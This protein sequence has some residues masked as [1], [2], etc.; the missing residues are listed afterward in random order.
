MKTETEIELE[1]ILTFNESEQEIGRLSL[2]TFFPT[3]QA[4]VW[5]FKGMIFSSGDELI[6]VSMCVFHNSATPEWYR[7]ANGKLYA[8]DLGTGHLV[9]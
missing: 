9:N 1:Y 8:K 2:K 5:F 4:A 6:K 3:K 7:N